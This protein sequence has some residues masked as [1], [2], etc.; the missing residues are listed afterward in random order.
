MYLGQ[1][2][3][4]GETSR[5]FERPEHPYTRGLLASVPQIH[6]AASAPPPRLFGDIPSPTHL[7]SGCRFHTRC[8]ERFQPCDQVAPRLRSL[9]DRS[10]RCHLGDPEVGP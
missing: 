10:L 6:R 7:P 2:V 1:V 8:P 5:V 3:E 9:A 4:H